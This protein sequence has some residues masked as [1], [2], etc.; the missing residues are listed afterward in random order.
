MTNGTSI[1]AE[2]FKATELGSFPASWD[3]IAL[4][5]AFDVQQGKALSPSARSSMSPR[6]FLRTANVLWGC[7]DL[8]SVD[9]MDFTKEEEERLSL[10]PG[11]LLVCEG[12]EIGRTATWSGE[13]EGCFYQNHVHRL[14]LAKEGILPTFVMYWMQAAFLHL[15]LYGGVG[16]KTTI[17][18][19]SGARLKQLLIPIPPP[20]D[21]R[22]IAAVLSKIQAAVE[23]QDRIVTTLKEL[24]AATMAKLFHEGLRGERLKQT[25]IGEI[26]ESWKVV[27]LDSLADL[28]SGGTPSKAR[29]EWWKGSIPWASPKEMKQPRLLD[30]QDHITEEA[31]ENGSRLVP[32]KTIFVVI[33]GMILAK[34]VPVAITEVPMAFNQDMKA[35]IPKST[36]D[37]DFLFY[38]ICSRTE[39]LSKAISTSA[40][41]TRRMGTASVEEL[42]IPLPTGKE[43]QRSIA[44]TLR[45][46]E[47]AEE[48]ASKKRNEL[49]ALFSSMLHLLMTGQVRV[50]PN[51]VVVTKEISHG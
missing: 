40:H 41:G 24:K 13:I 39:A 3:L 33:R 34:V 42:L 22:T 23:V 51:T 1:L 25:E 5:D 35:A 31:I 18:N 19:L 49:K 6:P 37:A 2:P 21:Q 26:P 44:R 30:T 29:L 9:R 7:L 46:L 27:R 17:P 20:P 50:K 12:G 38:A 32:A 11:D 15:R 48:I 14:R 28:V 8:T 47:E 10:K 36:V 4:G 16:N 45:C 43:E